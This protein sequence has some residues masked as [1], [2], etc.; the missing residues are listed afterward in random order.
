M[1]VLPAPLGPII[2][3]INPGSIFMSTWERALSP[4]KERVTS[5]TFRYAI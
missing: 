1:L 5:E 4:P 3:V 2:E